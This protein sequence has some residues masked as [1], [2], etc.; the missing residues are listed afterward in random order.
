MT[1]SARLDLYRHGGDS[2][3]GRYHL[4]RLHPLS[5][6]EL[7]LRSPGDLRRLL[8]LGG[9]P[10]PFFGGDET[11]ANLSMASMN[12]LI[13]G[14]RGGAAIVAGKGSE[15]LLVRKLRGV[16]IEGQRMPLGRPPLPD[17]EILLVE[18]WI[19]QGARL[20]LLTGE[21]SLEVVVAAGQARKL[22]DVELTQVRFAAGEKLWRRAIPDEEPVTEQRG[23]IGL[24][25]NLPPERMA[26]LA[27][28]AADVAG[29]VRSELA[30][31]DEPLLKGGVVVYAVKQAIDYSALWQNVVGAERP[32]GVAGHAGVSG[33]VVYGAFL[34]PS[35]DAADDLRVLVAEV[36]AGAAFAGRNV[37]PWFSRGAGR[38]LAA[39]VAPKADAVQRWRREAVAALPRL[40]SVADFL[41]GH[42][43]P[44]AATAAAGGFVTAIATGGKL[45]QV[46]GLLDGGATFDEAFSK[47]FKAA[48]AQAFEKWAARV[49]R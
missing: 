33:E 10:E 35:A 49:A 32:K 30:A 37:P 5:A 22:S 9:F 11:E 38:A 15:S 34:A 12:R 24:I 23:A 13:R 16:G 36:V 44:G 6:G 29:R 8:T 2:L 19:A 40:G 47:V 48:P 39:R 3:Q 7:G 17:A 18:R 28:T 26:S 14:G 46:I 41:D 45:H 1:G 4:L 20:D 42:A 31:A 43:E 27:D 21:S 25:G